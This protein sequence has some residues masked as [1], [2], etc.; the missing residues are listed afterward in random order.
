MLDRDTEMGVFFD[1][2]G[3]QGGVKWSISCQIYDEP[4]RKSKGIATSKYLNGFCMKK[5]GQM[6][7]DVSTS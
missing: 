6:L 4:L 5:S 1:P 2:S 3:K 7:T